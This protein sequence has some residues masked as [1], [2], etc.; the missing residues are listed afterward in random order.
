MTELT[1]GGRLDLRAGGVDGEMLGTFEVPQNETVCR[2][3]ESDA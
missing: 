1:T 2:T 3:Y